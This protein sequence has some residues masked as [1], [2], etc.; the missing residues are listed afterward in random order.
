M[1]VA[2][3]EAK[4]WQTL[5]QL[6]ALAQRVGRSLLPLPPPLLVLRPPG[7]PPGSGS[8]VDSR[9]AD[10]G[11]SDTPAANP[12]GVQPDPAEVVDP[13]PCVESSSAVVDPGGEVRVSPAEPGGPG[14]SPS[15][16]SEGEAAPA[17]TAGGRP[18]TSAAAEGR[19]G[20]AGPAPVDLAGT[21]GGASTA[22]Y[23]PLRRAQRLVYQ[24][25][26][27]LVDSFD[28]GEGRQVIATAGLLSPAR[29]DRR[30]CW[31]LVSV[32][33]EWLALAPL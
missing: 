14:E 24:L 25:A 32:C 11:S 23:P 5:D 27:L 29:V 21:S 6:E 8:T 15:T 2:A 1:Q 9:G 12:A 26:S 3:L 31:A 19:G 4:I 28:V 17:A 22:E 30:L 7:A 18:V 16:V 10:P 33:P 13:A 20:P